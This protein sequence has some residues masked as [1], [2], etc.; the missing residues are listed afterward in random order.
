MTS[1]FIRDEIV[2]G[3]FDNLEHRQYVHKLV[4]IEWFA[5]TDQQFGFPSPV[6]TNWRLAAQHPQAFDIVRREVDEDTRETARIKGK[7]SHGDIDADAKRREY[8]RAWWA[9]Q[10]QN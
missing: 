7:I 1:S 5:T 2:Q 4:W 10:E 9:V 6:G 3:S 8:R